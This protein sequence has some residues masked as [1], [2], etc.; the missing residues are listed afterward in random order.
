MISI[1]EEVPNH[2][3]VIVIETN[4]SYHQAEVFNGMCYAWCYGIKMDEPICRVEDI[5]KWRRCSSLE[6]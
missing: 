4:L 3:D 5:K 2:G 6:M 1:F